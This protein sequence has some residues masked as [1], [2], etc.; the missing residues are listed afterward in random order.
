MTTSIP[1]KIIDLHDD[2]FHPLLEV[3][4]FGKS[5]IMVLDTG[6]SKTAFDRATLFEANETTSILASDRLST[7]LG[8]NSMESFTAVISGMFV[9]DMPIHDFEVA[10]LDLSTINIAYSQMGHPQVLGV[11][12]GDIL[13]KY[14]AVIDYN[15]QVLKLKKPRFSKR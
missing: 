12:G 8:T 7:G 15:K 13:M 11:L 2:G 4:L 1:L 5:F 10:V 9:G 3:V 14:R 6:A